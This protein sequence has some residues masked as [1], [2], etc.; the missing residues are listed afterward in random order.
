MAG[1]KMTHV[2]F[3]FFI[4]CNLPI[5]HDVALFIYLFFFE[6]SEAESVVRTLYLGW[7]S[8]PQNR[9]LVSGEVG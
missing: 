4:S 9:Y 1:R 3:S 6:S 2:F 7:F 8:A 5:T